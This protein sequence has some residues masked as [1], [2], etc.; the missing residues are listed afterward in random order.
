MV[1]RLTPENVMMQES[2]YVVLNA[3]APFEPLL[4]WWQHDD[5]ASQ[6]NASFQAK[7]HIHKDASDFL[8]HHSFKYFKNLKEDTEL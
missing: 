3:H 8:Y 2:R 6:E 1:E 7:P 4:A 5:M